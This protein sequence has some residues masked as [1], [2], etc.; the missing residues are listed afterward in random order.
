MKKFIIVILVLVYSNLA[1]SQN[2]VKGLGLSKCTSFNTVSIQEK[3][4][5]MS[6]VAGFLTS[7]NI[8][9]DKLHV[10][11]ITYNM[12]QSWLESFCYKNP[13]MIF[14]DAVKKFIFEF[15]K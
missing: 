5:Y 8:L 1:F 4:I 9:K 3:V 7:H 2:K 15:T 10:K 12:T 11:N 6:W 14:K 13:N